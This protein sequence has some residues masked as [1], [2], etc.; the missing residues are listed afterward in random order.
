M[1]ST[2]ASLSPDQAQRAIMIFC[3]LVPTSFWEGGARPSPAKIE[4]TVEKLED[5]APPEARPI[6]EALSGGTEEQKGEIAKA[7]LNTFHE[8]E[9][10]SGFVDQAVEQ[11]QQPHLSPLPLIVGALTLVLLSG[12]RLKAGGGKGVQLEIAVTDNIKALTGGIET[13]VKQI[14]KATLGKLF[15]K[16]MAFGS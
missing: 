14:P 15:P 11:A 9:T 2:I 10:L 6:V 5:N 4:R 3:D 16:L 12:V 8:Q 1:E 13:I 7:L